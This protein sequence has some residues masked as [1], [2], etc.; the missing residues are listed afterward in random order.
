ML[1]ATPARAGE[2]LVTETTA[3]KVSRYTTDCLLWT[4]EPDFASGTYAGEAL[5]NPL[6]LAADAQGRVYVSE[7]RTGGRILRFQPDGTFLEV[8]AKSGVDFTGNPETLRTGPDGLIYISLAFG[9]NNNRILRLDPQS[10]QV[11]AILTSGLNTPRGLAFDAQGRLWIA[12]RGSFSSATG[13]LARYS[14]GVLTTVDSGLLRPTALAFDPATS[15]ILGNQGAT[16]DIWSYEASGAKTLVHDATIATSLDVKRIEGHL[17]YTDYDSGKVRA[18]LASNGNYAVAGGLA[19]PGHLLALSETPHDGPCSIPGSPALPGTTIAYSPP[20]SNI[21][22]G[23]PTLLRCPDGSLLASHDFFGGGSTQGT[24]GQTFLYRS[25]DDGAIWSPQ[26]EI[27]ALTTPG[28]DDDGVFWNSLFRHGTSIYSMGAECSVG[29]LVIRRSTDSGRSWT[30]VTASQG[31]LVTTSD[32]RAQA[33]GVLTAEAYGRVWAGLEHALSGTFGDTRLTL[34]SADPEADLLQAT[35]WSASNGVTRNTSWLGGTFAGWLEA[36]PVPTPDGGLVMM[37]RVD[38]RYTNGAAIGMK[39]AVIRATPTVPAALAF[40][41]GDFDPDT[42]NSSGFVDFPGGCVRFIVRYDETSSR[43]WSVCSYI[44]RA[45]RSNQYNAERFRGILALVSSANLRDWSVERIVAHD[46]RLYSTDAATL[47]SA[48]DGP[49]GSSSPKYY[50][51]DFGLQYAY[52]V[53]EGDDLLATIRTAWMD[54][55]GGAG[56]GHDANYYQFLRVPGFR[57]RSQDSDFRS[58]GAERVDA[59]HF[60]IRFQARP[61]RLYRL[62]SSPDLATWTPTEATLESAGGP[63][64]FTVP[65]GPARFFYRVAEVESGWKP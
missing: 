52:F 48:F 62:E 21:F 2:V 56:A 47:A 5:A 53:I 4:R 15:T 27:R 6:G 63:A 37:A 31:K 12:N 55:E 36:C 60:A 40:S 22:L 34:L 32:G 35:N 26:G 46:P 51:T 18:M 9:S 19:N 58:L 54:G 8:V 28:P 57:A 16:Q 29:D 45:F 61:A 59:T 25:S 1:A 43:Y 11:T 44:P 38:N 64:S 42:P 50:H 20:S 10:K 65:K 33:C 23:S 39:A 3:G 13:F 30:A 7:Q 49:Y 41:G 17:Y 14:G 24:T